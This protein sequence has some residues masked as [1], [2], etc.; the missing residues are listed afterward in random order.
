M[1]TL[2]LPACISPIPFPLLF[3]PLVLRPSPLI[4]VRILFLLDSTHTITS[5]H[6]DIT[7]GH[8][9]VTSVHTDVTSVHTDVTSDKMP[10]DVTSEPQMWHLKYGYGLGITWGSSLID[11]MYCV[12]DVTSCSR[13]NICTRILE[14]DITSEKQCPR[15][16]IWAHRCHIWSLR[17]HTWQT[18]KRALFD[19]PKDAFPVCQVW[20]LGLQMWHLCAPDVTS[21]ATI[22]RCDICTRDVASGDRRYHT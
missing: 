14:T 6:T 16:N 13:C 17:C 19:L 7:S 5:A 20:H 2:C 22:I 21:R 18:C 9:D 8:T 4:P 1:C 11:V 10:W 3:M 12:S 15:C